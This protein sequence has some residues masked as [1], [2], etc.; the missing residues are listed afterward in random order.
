ME[1]FPGLLTSTICLVLAGSFTFLLAEAMRSST[2]NRF[3]QSQRNC[4]VPK[5]PYYIL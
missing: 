2:E 3:V 4:K 1:A 5:R